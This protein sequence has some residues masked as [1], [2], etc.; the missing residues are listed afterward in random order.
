L[1]AVATV[2]RKVDGERCPFVG[3]AS[4]EEYAPL[5]IDGNF[6]KARPEV[7]LGK[8]AEAVAL[9]SAFPEQLSGIYEPAELERR[10]PTSPM[11]ARDAEGNP[12]G[13]TSRF[14]LEREMFEVGITDPA[15]R[16]AVIDE[17]L[18]RHQA[19]YDADP[20][21]FYGLVWAAVTQN[22]RRYGAA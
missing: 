14:Q 7:M 1:R 15:A 2:Y 13:P 10:P 22:P 21:G 5:G 6:W 20:E 12:T 18:R 9:R 3:E 8:C 17:F 19:I 16:A 4:W 11:P